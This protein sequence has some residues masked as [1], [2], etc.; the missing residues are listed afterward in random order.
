M[1]V[2]TILNPDPEC[3]LLYVVA[4]AVR[5]Q[6]RTKVDSGFLAPGQALLVSDT[7]VVMLVSRSAELA[8]CALAVMVFEPTVIVA[9]DEDPNNTI[10]LVRKLL[11]LPV[12][13]TAQAVGG[14]AR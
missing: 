12:Q 4:A 13:R 7:Q 10:G 6:N 2:T 5:D 14:E 3:H 9:L 8:D 1:D 11:G